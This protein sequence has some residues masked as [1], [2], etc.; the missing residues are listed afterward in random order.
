[1]QSRTL[2]VTSALS[3]PYW[4]GCR[5][6]VLRMQQCTACQQLQFYPRI[7]CA[8]CGESDLQWQ[9]VSGRATLASF[10]IVRHAISAAYDAPYVVALVDL[11]EGPRMMTGIVGASP[12]A[13]ETGM[14]LSVCFENWSEDIVV[15]MFRVIDSDSESGGSV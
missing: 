10:T 11:E 4:E 5:A 14:P 15:P 13:L 2:P 7:F 8:S 9:D 3:Q 1:M 6:G 12:E